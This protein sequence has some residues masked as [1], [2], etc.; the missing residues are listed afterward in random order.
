MLIQFDRLLA[1]GVAGG[2]RLFKAR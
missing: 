1:G 2:R